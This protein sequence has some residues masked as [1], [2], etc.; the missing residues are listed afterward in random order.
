MCIC[1][2]CTGTH[3]KVG[4][5]SNCVGSLPTLTREVCV[6]GDGNSHSV[7][8]LPVENSKHPAGKIRKASSI[9]NWGS[10]I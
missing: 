10:L 8:M 7:G 2:D 3:L 1:F 4:L 5:K 9:R 6:A